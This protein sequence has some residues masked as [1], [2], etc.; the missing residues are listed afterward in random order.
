MNEYIK[1]RIKAKKSIEPIIK[2][3]KQTKQS[4]IYLYERTDEFGI[5]YFYC[6][7]AKNIFER[8]IGHWQQYASRLDKSLHTR[9]FYSE[10]NPHG[11]KFSVLEYCDESKLNE[12]E[13]Y[14]ILLNL[15]LGK[16]SYNLTYGGDEGKTQTFGSKERKGYNQGLA[17]GYLKARKE[18]AKL[19]EKNLAVV[20]QGSPNKLKERALWKFQEFINVEK[21]NE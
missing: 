11:W 21:E 15:Q 14:Y 9:G 10:N 12:R 4:G 19:F 17:N 3:N 1:N 5:T 2:E 20:F 13:T 7:K 8:Q 6:G 18:I 16:Q